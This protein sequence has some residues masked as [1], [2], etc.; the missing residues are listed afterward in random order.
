MNNSIPFVKTH[1]GLLVG[2]LVLLA[3]MFSGHGVFAADGQEQVA[4]VSFLRGDAT[5]TRGGAEAMSLKRGDKLVAGDMVETG[6]KSMVQLVFP[7]KQMF[8]VKA[9]SSIKL[10][11]FHF[12]A[13]GDATADAS[14]TELLKGGM[15]S[16]SGLVGRN[17]PAN[18]RYRAG[19]TT[20]GIRGTA[21]EI[22]HSPDQATAVSFDYGKGYVEVERPNLC[23]KTQMLRGDSVIVG[24]SDVEHKTLVRADEDPS[25]A[26]SLLVHASATERSKMAEELGRSVSLEDALFTLAMLRELPQF[27]DRVLYDAVTGLGRSVSSADVMP[28]LMTATMLYPAEAPLI[29]QAA[30]QSGQSL[31]PA[32]RGVMCGLDNESPEAMTQVV[33]VA[34]DLGVTKEEAQKV[35]GD[36]ETRGCS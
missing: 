12:G 26:A 11:A 30:A 35:L 21:I 24:R 14:V 15:R 34:L 27:Q 25:K 33:R 13:S 28:L 17:S 6:S 32:V 19:E 22:D 16:I 23:I 8:Y 7:D 36:L 9:D 5:V 1:T 10:E 3:A 20:I 31:V 29:L 18:V 4:R 2:F